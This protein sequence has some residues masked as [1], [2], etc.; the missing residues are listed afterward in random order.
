MKKDFN[1]GR[2]AGADP[3]T[4]AAAD[5]PGAAA[6][7]VSGVAVI[8]RSALFGNPEKAQGRIS[9]DGKYISFIAPRNRRAQ[10]VAGRARQARRRQ[11]HHQ[12]SEARHPPALWAFDN[13]H[14]LYQQDNDGDE[15]W[16]VH[17]VDV[18]T[19]RRPG[20]SRLTR[21]ARSDIVDLSWEKARCRGRGHLRSRPPSGR[22]C[23]RSISPPANVRWW[24]RT[25]RRSPAGISTS[26]SRPKLA[27]KNNPDGSE[28][29]RRVGDKWVSVLKFGQEDSLT[30]AAIAVKRAA[31][32]R[33]CSPPSAAT[34]RRWNASTSQWQDHRARRERSGRHRPGVAE[35]ERPRRRR[36]T[37]STI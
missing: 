15:N 10:R 12:R 31:L 7:A 37:P 4:L 13:R 32:P 6:Q 29:L 11:A 1:S 17:A 5:A 16:H 33:C 22:T 26:T 14:V 28:I 8:P 21:G 18:T 36:R 3:P 34:R 25:P 19:N 2:C 35:P 23:G 30:T 9:P 24:N 27:Q 20:T